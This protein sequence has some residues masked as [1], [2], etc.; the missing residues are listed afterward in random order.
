M[1]LNWTSMMTKQRVEVR[2]LVSPQI[3]DSEVDDVDHHQEVLLLGDAHHD[4]SIQTT[5]VAVRK[6]WNCA[7]TGILRSPLPHSE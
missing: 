2:T 5:M 3:S 4:M 1:V 6:K 7:E